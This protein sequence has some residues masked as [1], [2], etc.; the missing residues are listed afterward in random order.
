MAGL[1]PLYQWKPH[2]FLGGLRLAI[3]RCLA[4][5]TPVALAGPEAYQS[6]PRHEVFMP[7]P[8]TEIDQPSQKT[9]HLIPGNPIA[10]GSAPWGVLVDEDNNTAY[11]CNSDGSN[12]LP[13]NTRTR[14]PGDPIQLAH[15][16]ELAVLNKRTHT[17]YTL[18]FDGYVMPIDTRTNEAGTPVSVEGGSPRA[19]TQNI[20]LNQK[21]D[22]LYVA[23]YYGG[24]IYI[25]DPKSG[26]QTPDSPIVLSV[27]PQD[28]EIDEANDTLYVLYVVSDS[29]NAGY[30]IPISTNSPDPEVDPIAVG[31]APSVMV[32]DKVNRYLYISN[33]DRKITTLF[34]PTNTVDIGAIDHGGLNMAAMAVD[35]GFQ[36]LYVAGSDES[37]QRRG[38]VVIFRADIGKVDGSVS[39]GDLPNG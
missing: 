31:Y 34:T 35:E 9:M 3:G 24:K 10:A 1:M 23:D 22:L 30:V 8:S 20:V 15:S 16:P 28:I 18:S 5:W 14:T 27:N 26:Q 7:N 33:N 38:R 4:V 2:G 39:V 25:I 21:Q 11:V 12:V 32:L 29:S 13:I 17:L 36:I 6:K 19:A 37:A